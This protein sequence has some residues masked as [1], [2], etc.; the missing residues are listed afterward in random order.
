[1]KVTDFIAKYY[2]LIIPL[3]LFVIFFQ[4]TEFGLVGLEDNALLK[5]SFS[6][7]ATGDR[8]GIELFKSYLETDSYRP[9]TNVY[10]WALA[11]IAGNNPLIFRL[12]NFL[13]L[14]LIS[15]ILVKVFEILKFSKKTATISVLLALVHPVIFATMGWIPSSPI[16][17]ATLFSLLSFWLFYYFLKKADGFLLFLQFISVFLTIGSHES[18]FA[19]PFLLLAFLFLNKEINIS[20]SQK[21]QAIVSWVIAI[22]IYFLMMSNSNLGL[23]VSVIKFENLIINI[24]LIPEIIANFFA[25]INLPVLSSFSNFKTMIGLFI[26]ALLITMGKFSNILNTFE[27]KFALIWFLVSSLP[28]IL[29]IPFNAQN[30]YNYQYIW[31]FFASIGLLIYLAQLISKI[32]FANKF[33]SVGFVIIHF[34][35]SFLSYYNLQNYK[36]DLAFFEN[37]NKHNPENPQILLSLLD[38]YTENGES[39]LAEKYLKIASELKLKDENKKMEI[40][41]KLSEFYLNQNRID[42][43][44]ETLKKLVKEYD[45]FTAVYQIVSLYL[46]TG[47]VDDANELAKSQIRNEEEKIKIL[48]IYDIWA[49]NYHKNKDNVTMM[50]V[51]KGVLVFD[52]N[53]LEVVNYILKTYIQ[54]YEESKAAF[55]TEK[56]KFYMNERN[57]ILAMNKENK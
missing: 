7:I 13:I 33:Y 24:Q 45:N 39:V 5:S 1:M 27:S 11:Q 43:S 6:R 30:F 52:P 10:N 51:M 23:E 55:L 17:L 57:R 19:L 15:I 36:N 40:L 31:G 29:I 56:I 8:F 26:I 35:L 38:I 47:K 41:F 49:K 34:V 9:M 48:N 3:F 28:F 42:E 46:Q 21:I 22:I 37:A 20:L 16:L 25:P 4:T 32:D 44:I 53:N 18:G 12:F 50:K 54:L 2:F 14:S